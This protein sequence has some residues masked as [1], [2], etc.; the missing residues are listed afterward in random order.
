MS[1]ALRA[2]LCCGFLPLC[3][4][5]PFFP[6]RASCSRVQVGEA[7]RSSEHHPLS[8]LLLQLCLSAKPG[9]QPGS[10]PVP[11]LVPA[12]VTSVGW[13]LPS[14]VARKDCY[15]EIALPLLEN[16]TIIQQPVNLSSLAARYVE[17]AARFIQRARSDVIPPSTI[18][19]AGRARGSLQASSVGVMLGGGGGIGCCPTVLGEQIWGL[20]GSASQ[21]TGGGRSHRGCHQCPARLTLEDFWWVSS[22]WV[23]C[24]VKTTIYKEGQSL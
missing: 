20:R 8:A 15:T 18:P 1:P 23:A 12:P 11:T 9:E 5:H 22:E 7:G 3:S 24:V 16:V 13:L 17:E 21:P 6:L 14:R 4:A 10:V 2:A 19:F